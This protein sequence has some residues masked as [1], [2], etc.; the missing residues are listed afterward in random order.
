MSTKYG[1]CFAASALLATAC[2]LT[3]QSPPET[4]WNAS[5]GPA[6]IVRNRYS[7]DA[8]PIRNRYSVPGVSPVSSDRYTFRSVIGNGLERVLTTVHL[9]L[10][11]GNHPPGPD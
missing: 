11:V 3:P 9:S 8:A 10:P 6:G 5:V 7:G 2:G 1:S 4:K